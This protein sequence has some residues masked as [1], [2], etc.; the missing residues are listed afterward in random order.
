MSKIGAGGL[1]YVLVTMFMAIGAINAQ[2][3][4]LF[5]L[6][7]AALGGIVSSGFIGGMGMMGVCASRRVVGAAR[8]GEPARVTYRVANINRRAA[9]VA[10]SFRERGAPIDFIESS[11][12][13]LARIG[14]GDELITHGYVLAKRRGEIELPAFDVS[15]SYP[16]G[17]LLKRLHFEQSTMLLA[18]PARVELAPDLLRRVLGDQGRD[19]GSSRAIGPGEEFFGIR[20]YRPG[21]PVRHI[22][23]RSSAKGSGHRVMLHTRQAPRALWVVIGVRP[24]PEPIAAQDW[25][26]RALGDPFEAATTIAAAAI[27]AARDAGLAFGLRIPELGI[28]VATSAGGAHAE[29]CLDLLASA[30]GERIEKEAAAW[31]PGSRE[32][33]LY[34]HAGDASSAPPGAVLVDSLE[35]SAVIRGFVVDRPG[36][37]RGRA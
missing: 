37:E 21:D 20:E 9:A 26:E 19:G 17:L 32:G 7:G 28:E 30:S 4:L 14:P 12:A 24:T 8:V 25:R 36:Y 1:V 31:S 10:L 6:F 16:I 3:N 2:N 29:R 11:L 13:G 27:E 22:A 18:R 35:P 15:S 34:L 5:W 33:C 23:W